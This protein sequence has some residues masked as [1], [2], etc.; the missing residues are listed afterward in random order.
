LEIPDLSLVEELFTKVSRSILWTLGPK[1]A[2]QVQQTTD[3]L[4]AILKLLHID[5]CVLAR[6][7]RLKRD[8]KA[9]VKNT[10]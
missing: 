7:S 1:W 6:T 3:F 8:L 5:K 4:H 9:V 10:L 2:P